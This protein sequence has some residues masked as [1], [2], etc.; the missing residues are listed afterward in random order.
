MIPILDLKEGVYLENCKK[1]VSI[2]SSVG[3]VYL[4]NHGVPPEDIKSCQELFHEF[5]NQSVEFKETFRENQDNPFMGYKACET[6]RLDPTQK[7][8][9]MREAMVFYAHD[10]TAN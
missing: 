5:F 7:E 4:R 2:L 6:E 10:I 1:L 9:D 8:K 3:F